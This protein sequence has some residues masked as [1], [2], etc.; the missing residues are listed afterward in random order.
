MVN[1]KRLDTVD[2]VLDWFDRTGLEYVHSVPSI[3]FQES[4]ED[5][6]FHPPGCRG[7]RLDR[8]IA[9]MGWMFSHGAEGGL[10]VMMARKPESAASSETNG[11]RAPRPEP[12]KP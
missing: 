10:F 9:Q 11:S 8:W 4:F 5:S 1:V 12:D 7:S 3:A 2:E 6:P